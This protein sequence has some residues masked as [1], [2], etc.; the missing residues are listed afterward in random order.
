MHSELANLPACN[1][2]TIPGPS[3]PPSLFF[4]SR[5]ANRVQPRGP[6]WGRHRPARRRLRFMQF[7]CGQGPPLV[8]GCHWPALSATRSSSTDARRCQLNSAG[9][10]NGPAHPHPLHWALEPC[11][12]SV[13]LWSPVPYDN[14]EVVSVRPA[15]VFPA[16]RLM[17]PAA[18][19]WV[20]H[21]V[22]S[23]LT[24]DVR[25]SCISSPADFECRASLPARHFSI[26]L[27]KRFCIQ[28]VLLCFLWLQPHSLGAFVL[29]H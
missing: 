16:H 5:H 28:T 4:L 1:A 3:P 14:T 11:E 7:A 8:A 25:V 26:F 24:G 22:S 6:R 13:G 10:G 18:C 2:S 9:A 27:Y 19:A 12:R 21:V 29:E 20:Q 15:Y 23:S 17:T